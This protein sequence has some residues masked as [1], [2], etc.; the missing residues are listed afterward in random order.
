MLDFNAA[1]GGWEAIVEHVNEQNS[2]K[3][4][5]GHFFESVKEQIRADTIERIHLANVVANVPASEEGGDQLIT[6]K[7][8]VSQHRFADNSFM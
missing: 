2:L 3:N 7:L 5:S 6:Q 1:G 4:I 8:W